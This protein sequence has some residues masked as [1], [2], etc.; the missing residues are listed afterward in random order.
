MADWSF[1]WWIRLVAHPAEKMSAQ[2]SLQLL[3]RI[4]GRK[5]KRLLLLESSFERENLAEL[6]PPDR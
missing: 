6:V 4:E 5:E 3:D 2:V 1:G